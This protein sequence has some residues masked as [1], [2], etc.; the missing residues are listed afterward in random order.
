MACR[1]WGTSNRR[2]SGRTV[3]RLRRRRRVQLPG[4]PIA[5]GLA[6][7]SA[8]RLAAARLA[9]PDCRRLAA[10]RGW[11]LAGDGSA[12]WRAGSLA[13]GRRQPRAIIRTFAVPDA[14]SLQRAQL[15]EVGIAGAAIVLPGSQVNAAAAAIT[16]PRMAS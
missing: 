8:D 12:T 13:L 5:D 1:S 16:L 6:K 9:A 10:L 11:G 14:A 15:S 7:A 3:P 2:S 4:D